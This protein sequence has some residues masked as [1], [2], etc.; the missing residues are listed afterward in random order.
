MESIK[1][2]QICDTLP[3]GVHV[4]R[5]HSVFRHACNLQ[6]P[7]GAL[8]VLQTRDV[9]LSPGGII[10][11]HQ[12]LRPF[13]RPGESVRVDLRHAFAQSTRLVPGGARVT[14]G[15]LTGVID[16]FFALHAA[17]GVRQALA[18]DERLADAQRGLV[19]WLRTPRSDPTPLARAFVGYGEGLT[20][21]GDDYL[22]GLLWTLDNWR[23]V[24]RQALVEALPALLP[25]TTDVSRAM[26]SHGCES[27]YGALLLALAAADITRLPQAV[28]AVARYGHSSGEDMLAGMRAAA[29]AL[30]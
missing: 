3:R 2:L 13:F 10:I 4:L 18:A 17:K 12:D 27:R 22:L 1:G 28:Q 21:A 26:L 30:A 14:L 8:W 29:Y 15:Q 19:R 25:R 16:D 6:T 11:D 9:P 20:P 24:Q 7:E 23:A 5:A